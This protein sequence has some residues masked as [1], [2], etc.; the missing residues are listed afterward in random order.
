MHMTRGITFWA[1]VATMVFELGT[2]AGGEAPAGDEGEMAAVRAAGREYVAAALRNDTEALRRS[3]TEEG[4]YIDATGRKVKARELIGTKAPARSAA[5]APEV[6][7][8]VQS[9][10][11]FITPKVAIEDGTYDC[12]TEDGG[13]EATGRFTA[14]W[15]KQ[16]DRWLLDSLR[17]STTATPPR[18]EEL[19]PLEWLVGEWVGVADD[20]VILVSSRWSDSG[21]YIIR[22]LAV[23]GD[24]GEVTGTERIGWDPAANEFKSW[25]FDSQ[26]GRGESRWKL[27][28]DRWVIET[29]DVTADGKKA[30]TSAIVTRAGDDQYVWEV[31]SSK[32]G[33]QNVPQRR[34]QFTR[35]PEVE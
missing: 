2:A 19:K 1:C 21:N 23:I 8:A 4:D 16:G 3:W 24:G 22:E 10:I 7:D 33:D 17:E 12:G 20:S 14:V 30:T 5:R 13:S 11:R 26:D 28:G 31:K 32:V 27:D 18:R 34:V 9:E 6:V 35:A 15:V 25:T 29:T